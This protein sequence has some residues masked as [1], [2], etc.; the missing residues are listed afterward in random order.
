[1]V[2]IHRS[3]QGFV[4]VPANWPAVL[5]WIVMLTGAVVLV[6]GWG[7]GSDLLRRLHPS[8]S[9][10]VPSTAICFL[11]SGSA[12]IAFLAPSD[13]ALRR[14]GLWFA[15]VVFAIALTDVVV[16]APDTAKGI[17]TLVWPS[18]PVFQSAGMA[19]ATATCFLFA[20]LA[21]FSLAARS[22][23]SDFAFQFC[24]TLGLVLALVALAGY[25]FD[26]EALYH[27]SVFTAMA[28]HTALTFALLFS[29]LLLLRPDYGWVGLI[30]GPGEGSAGA[31]RLV[32]AVIL[33]PLLLC[34]AALLATEAGIVDASF[35]LS[36]LAIITM[37]VLA[38]TVLY[39]A[40]IQNR[41]ERR[42]RETSEQLRIAL[43]ERNVLM[44][45]VYNRVGKNL[46]QIHSL[47]R[48]EADEIDNGQSRRALQSLTMRIE[49]LGAVHELLVSSK[50]LSDLD[51]G[52][53]LEQLCANIGDGIRGRG[54]AVGVIVEA[55]RHSIGIDQAMTLGLLVN[56]LV[57]NA[58]NHAFP[59]DRG[60][61]IVVGYGVGD[62]GAVLTVSDDGADMEER[63]AVS[64]T[65]GIAGGQIL[66]TLIRKLDAT[67]S[68]DVKNGTT[69]AVTIP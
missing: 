58:L 13:C 9:A 3:V 52:T 2:K 22:I 59:G 45:E 39:N 57:V 4:A 32:P 66:H 23:G 38:A 19:P 56:E 61:T 41:S 53:F 31:R 67:M 69:I 20:A 49:A 63:E 21:L 36:A 68:V 48:I 60:G 37:L 40:A 43:E 1:M 62:D 27:V 64:L 24:A 46:Q 65:G 44:G 35:G 55:G 28:L 18:Q 25:L 33:F 11:L 14:S 12:V 8:F 34:L 17:D 7:L 10:M 47:V 29:A 42:L 16:I 51:A 54:R 26:A 15:V 50:A 5:A 6:G 30:L